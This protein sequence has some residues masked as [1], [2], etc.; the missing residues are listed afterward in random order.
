MRL[1]GYAFYNNVAIGDFLVQVL[2]SCGKQLLIEKEDCNGKRKPDYFVDTGV[3]TKNRHFR[4]V[5]SCKGGKNAV[6]MPTNRYALA[7]REGH[8]PSPAEIFLKTIVTKVESDVTLLSIRPLASMVNSKVKSASRRTVEDGPAE[9]LKLD[10]NEVMPETSAVKSTLFFFSYFFC[11]TWFCYCDQSTV[12]ADV[13]F[14]N[15]I[16]CDFILQS[17]A[18]L[19][20]KQS[21]T[22]R[23]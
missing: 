5:Y 23:K 19:L 4:I 3:Y 2:D 20:I 11:Q 22:S 8:H 13:A 18:R 14:Y 1:P 6:L 17:Y 9:S 10:R 21:L 12:H 15:T 7:R 16:L